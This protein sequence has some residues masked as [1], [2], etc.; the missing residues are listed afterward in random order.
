MEVYAERA[1]YNDP[2]NYCDTIYKI[3]GQWYGI[4]PDL[5]KLQNNRHRSRESR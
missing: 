4:P 3:A 2:W 1:I 5:L